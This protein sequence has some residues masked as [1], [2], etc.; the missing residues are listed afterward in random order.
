MRT[1]SLAIAG[2]A[3]YAIFLAAMAPARW[4]AAR[5][6][7]AAPGRYAVSD[8]EGTLWK[9]SAKALVNAPAGSLVVDRAEWDFLPS[10][11]LRGRLAFAIKLRGAGFDASYEAGRSLAGW[12]LRDLAIHAD[13]A[14]AA[15]ALPLIARWRPE[16]Q[17][18]VTSPALDVDGS[19]VSGTVRVD[20]KGAATSLSAVKPL[21]SYRAEIAGEG[22][23]GKLTVSTLEGPLRLAGQGRVEW[24]GRFQFKGEARGEGPHAKALEPLLEVLGPARP[25]GSRAL[26]WQLR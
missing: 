10:R 13:A 15:A 9:G 22:P 3:A 1:R 20:V 5:L 4:L 17:V 12:G 16:G 25:D 26:D 24:S 2:I 8:V 18:S 23:S 14:L 19:D 6:E 21:G 7:S 11:L